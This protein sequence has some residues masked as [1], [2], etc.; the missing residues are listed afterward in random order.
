MQWYLWIVNL[1]HK[2]LIVLE[3]EL[4]NRP[5][6]CCMMQGCFALQHPSRV[7]IG[8]RCSLYKFTQTLQPSP[9]CAEG[10]LPNGRVEQEQRVCGL[11]KSSVTDMS[12]PCLSS[13][14]RASA[15]PCAA[16]VWRGVQPYM[17][18]YSCQNTSQSWVSAEGSFAHTATHTGLTFVFT[19]ADCYGMQMCI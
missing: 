15:S 3:V 12:A 6:D 16:A 18:P 9:S 5:R 8:N 4:G 1:G 11:T 17:S 7:N 10:S 19:R 13:S 14:R 2:T